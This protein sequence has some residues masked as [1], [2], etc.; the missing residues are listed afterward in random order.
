M[1]KPEKPATYG[2]QD[3]DKHNRIYVGHHYSQRNTNNVNKT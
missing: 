1:D 3:K 2:S